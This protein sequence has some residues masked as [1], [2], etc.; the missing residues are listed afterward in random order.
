MQRGERQTI[1]PE[2]VV[3]VTD[4]REQFRAAAKP[5]KT[6]KAARLVKNAPVRNGPDAERHKPKRGSRDEQHTDR[7]EEQ[8][9]KAE[10]ISQIQHTTS[11]LKTK[12]QNDRLKT[13]VE[14]KKSGLFLQLVLVFAL[15]GGGAVVLD[16]TLLP[17]EVRNLDW[18]GM[19]VQ[20][21]AAIQ[22]IIDQ[23]S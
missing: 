16:P 23:A 4:L 14:K 22:Q 12:P 13:H 15:A 21:E 2:S 3:K 19:K 20:A 9:A 1:R 8:M 18:Q 11:L 10:R 7:H 17:A 5:G 6:A